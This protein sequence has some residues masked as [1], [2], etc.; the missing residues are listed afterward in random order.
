MKE[1][2]HSDLQMEV[3]TSTAVGAGGVETANL[4]AQ[5]AKKAGVQVR[6]NKVDS[7]TFYGERYLQW[8]FAQDF[9][10]TRNYIPQAAQSSLKDSPYNE[11]HFNDPE[12]EDL[13][14]RAKQE[15]DT[16]VRNDLL[17]RAQQIEYDTGGFI[18][19]GFKEQVDA[20]SQ[21]VEGLVPRRDLPMSSFLFK[22][23][24]LV[25]E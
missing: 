6:V 15:L 21:F 1:A 23:A 22:N 19:W 8:P 18:I 25:K 9:W 11:T 17:R 13:I 5:Q 14:D 24:R 7:A 16:D 4:F 2:G 20:Y 10:Y 12:F 3:V